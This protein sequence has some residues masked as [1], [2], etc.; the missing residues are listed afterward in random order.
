MG[1]YEKIAV[2]V[3]RGV[4]LS[5]LFSTLNELG[6]ISF[7]IL[8]SSLGI[9]SHNAI[10]YEGRLILAVFFLIS[11][12]VLFAR[13]KSLAKYLVEGLEDEKAETN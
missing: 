5:F 8:L 9:I 4:A 2:I 12:L 11:S 6:I 7:G 10:S 13:S 3:I 1:K